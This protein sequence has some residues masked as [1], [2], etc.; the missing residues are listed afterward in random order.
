MAAVA[1]GLAVLQH[2]DLVRALDGGHAL[3]NDNAGGIMEAL[4]QRFSQAGIGA[5]I[6]G[7]GGVIQYQQAGL[8][9]QRAGDE[10]ALFLPAGEV[11]A[12]G[13][14][15]K[16]QPAFLLVDKLHGLGSFCRLQ[17]F[18]IRQVAVEGNVVADGGRHDEVTLEGDAHALSQRLPGDGTDVLAFNQNAALLRVIQ[19][20]QQVGQRGFAAARGPDNAQ[21]L[22]LLQMKADIPQVVLD[23]VIA[24]GHLVK[25]NMVGAVTPRGV[26]LPLLLLHLKDG[27][28][29]PGGGDA[30]AG[31][32]EDAGDAEHAVGN[33][34][35][36]VHK[37]D[38]AARTGQAA[39]DQVGAQQHAQGQAQVKRD[40]AKRVGERHH[41]ARLAGDLGQF[42]ADRIKALLLVLRLAQRLDDAHAHDVLLQHA[43]QLVQHRLLLVIQRHGF[44]GDHIHNH[45]DDGHG[46][47]QH[48]HHAEIQDAGHHQAA[49]QQNGRAHAHALHAV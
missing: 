3:G 33:D 36:I 25:L 14:D 10:Q 13:L 16:V 8:A 34:G 37:G 17:D 9:R 26:Q 6:K 12:A 38:D 43:H 45:P 30:L 44:L 5:V 4:R 27:L 19:P 7:G 31:H 11:V 22:P 18:R 28:N 20:Q 46:E 32:D 29:A 41:A 35:E 24:E 42:A 49:H 48:Q 40:G 47:E 1:D 23:T 2:Q 21:G 15:L 39:V